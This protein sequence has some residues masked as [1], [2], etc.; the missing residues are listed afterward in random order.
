MTTQIE[1][2]KK[3]LIKFPSSWKD[4]AKLF[5]KLLDIKR[6][7]QIYL[8]PEKGE[9]SVRIR[10]TVEGLSGD[11]KIVYHFN[12][13]EFIEPGIHKETEEEI[14]Q[15]DYEKSLKKAHPD[16]FKIEK[17]RFVFEYEDQKFELDVFKGPL[18][19]L[20]ILELELESKNQKIKL[21]PYLTILKEVTNDKRY[22]NFN[23]ATKRHS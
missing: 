8:A 19:G 5:D 1:N 11:T 9:P 20:A 21:P 7:S 16:K 14:S 23:L 3:Y 6:I 17:I 13:K 15:K 22:N 2:E 10:K 4:L 12:K 18:E